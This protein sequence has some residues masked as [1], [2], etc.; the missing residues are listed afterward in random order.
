MK[1]ALL[2]G[3]LCGILAGISPGLAF[4]MV[5]IIAVA[6]M[7]RLYSDPKE[8]SFLLGLFSMGLLVRAACLVLLMLV[9]VGM[10]KVFVTG[11]DRFSVPALFG[12]SGY[13]IVRGWRF[14]QFFMGNLNAPELTDHL[15]EDYGFSGQLILYTL[16][17]SL[18]GFSPF[19]VTTLNC[20]FGVLTGL[21]VY[22]LTRE[23][24]G[25][26]A[27]RLAG[28]LT[29]FFP[30]LILW[31]VTNLKDSLFILVVTAMPWGWWRWHRSRRP[32]FLLVGIGAPLILLTL[33]PHFPTAILASFCT[34]VGLLVMASDQRRRIG[35]LCGAGGILLLLTGDLPAWYHKTLTLAVSYHR[36]V[37]STG[38][39]YYTLYGPGIYDGSIEPAAVGAPWVAIAYGIAWIHIL[40]EPF[41]WKVR[42]TLSL[43][44]LPQMLI[45]YSLLGMA[46]LGGRCLWKAN[47]RLGRVVFLHLFFLGSVIALGGGNVGTDFRMRDTLTPLILSLSA[48]GLASLRE[49]SL[50]AGRDHSA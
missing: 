24:A 28:L 10:D 25:T 23:V 13:A 16:F 42:S 46:L 27:A 3:V 47:P 4:V 31:S 38:G 9:L 21:V 12:D 41:P 18:F 7:I 29:T 20:L 5:L 19:A 14:V 32:L 22:S 44:A 43:A 50:S 48:M 35:M 45:W 17:F 40:L 6:G 26:F 34:T 2:L 30:S 8:T 11:S 33:R 37:V 15:M 36:G 1:R 39:F 49:T